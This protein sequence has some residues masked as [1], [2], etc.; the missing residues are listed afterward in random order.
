MRLRNPIRPNL[1]ICLVCLMLIGGIQ[2][3]TYDGMMDVYIAAIERKQSSSGEY[4]KALAQ[5]IQLAIKGTV[6]SAIVTVIGGIAMIL[7]RE[8]PPPDPTV[9]ASVHMALIDATMGG[10]GGSPGD[11]IKRIKSMLEELERHAQTE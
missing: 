8:Q 1:I 5:I 10:N 7:A 2:S 9:P 6:W 3:W 4:E 11:T